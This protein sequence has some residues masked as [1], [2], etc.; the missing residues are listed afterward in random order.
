MAPA[1]LP[2]PTVVYALCGTG[3]GHTSRAMAVAD[4]LRARGHRVLF[5]AG[6]PAASDLDARDGPVI[7]IPA[8]RQVVHANRVRLGETARVNWPHARHSFDIIAEAAWWL[9]RVRAD[10]V[11]ADHEPFVGR[12]ARRVGVPVVALS[13]QLLLVHARL[14]VPRRDALGA[15]G[16][17]RGIAVVAPPRP[18]ATVIPTFHDAQLRHGSSAQLV[19]P[20]LRD[21]V[22][23]QTVTGGERV[24][25]YL[26]EGD[27]METFVSALGRVDAPVDVFGL[28][29]GTPAPANVTLHAPDRAAFLARLG[30]CRAVVA[31]AGFTLLSEAL[32]LGKPVL[33]V[34]NRGFFE[35]MLNARAVVAAGRGEM[36]VGAPDVAAFLDRAARYAR[37]PATR[38]AGRA[39][40]EA[41]ADAVERVLAAPGSAGSG[42]RLSWP[43][44]PAPVAS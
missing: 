4:V 8:L 14:D 11:V 31:T 17:A 10:V 43:V 23:G 15:W 37:P 3:R 35:Q 6:A 29:A 22:L 7:P 20:V 30:A 33:A 40:R 32:H 16:T 24:L 27:G 12:A 1:R 25:V 26:N 19:P 39:G 42:G 2:L 41:A 44:I 13:R 5:A 28:P 18:D 9:S 21:D 38:E 34:P 36:A